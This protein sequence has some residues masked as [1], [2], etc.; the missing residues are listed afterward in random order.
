[1]ED[2]PDAANQAEDKLPQQMGSGTARPGNGAG[3]VARE[4]ADV[5]AVERQQKIE[6]LR[7]KEDYLEQYDPPKKKRRFLHFLGWMLLIVV[8]TAGGAAAGWYFWLR[9]EPKPAA[10]AYS[11]SQQTSTPP[12]AAEAAP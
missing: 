7:T 12:A 1:M 6:S 10:P 5:A 8:L 4:A 9:K 3:T 2:K 11:K